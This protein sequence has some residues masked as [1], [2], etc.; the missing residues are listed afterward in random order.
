MADGST[1]TSLYPD[2]LDSDTNQPGPEKGDTIYANQIEKL[3]ESVHGLE[4]EVGKLVLPAPSSVRQRLA[5][6][7]DDL[8]I[9]GNDLTTA[10][11]DILTLQNNVSTIQTTVVDNFDNSVIDPTLWTQTIPAGCSLTETTSL[12]FYV[13]G[14]LSPA[15]IAA[16]TALPFGQY[17]IR[18]HINLVTVNNNTRFGI[19]L[20][21]STNIV[22]MEFNRNGANYE[23]WS[24]ETGSQ[25]TVGSPGAATRLWLRWVYTLQGAYVF[26]STN[27]L[28]SPPADTDWVF[29]VYKLYTV[30][31]K[32]LKIRCSLENWSS[33]AATVDLNNLT[34]TRF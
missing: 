6:A 18:A 28:A 32:L 1:W 4:A 9:V 5:S 29:A 16:T 17:D 23:I 15:M 25:S 19:G 11:G 34:V 3:K 31:P 20:H 10:Q 24:S 21:D 8:V 13:T 33:S 27:L 2:S 22:R 14:T 12:R 30:M 7:E 26:Y